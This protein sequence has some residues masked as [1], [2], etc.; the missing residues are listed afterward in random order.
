MV[1]MACFLHVFILMAMH[2]L[3]L[4]WLR[5]LTEVHGTTKGCGMH[6]VQNGLD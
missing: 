5:H 4:F 1:L 3:G 6:Q 2:R